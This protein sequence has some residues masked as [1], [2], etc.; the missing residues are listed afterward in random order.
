MEVTGVRQ[1]QAWQQA[2]LPPVEQVRPGLWSIPVP[3][4]DN[5]LRYVLVY[6][7]ELPDGVAIVDP[8]WDCDEAWH[9]LVT[10]LRTVGYDIAE[11][12]AVLVTHLH[13]DHFG[14][15]G[16]VR[17]A[18]GAWVAMHRADA[19]LL[20]HHEPAEAF[21][22]ARESQGQLRRA[23]APEYL[24]SGHHA[25]PLVRFDRCAGAEVLLGD[26]DRLD[27]PGWNLHAVG[28]PGHTPG[29]LCLFER[30][31]GVLLSGDHVLPRISPHISLIPG[32]LAD[33]LTS[34]LGSLR[35]IAA[36][37]VDEVLPAH[38]YRFRGLAER[39]GALLSH[40]AERLAE[41][42]RAVA[43][44]PGA[45]AWQLTTRLTWSRPIESM[46]ERLLR[47][48]LRETLAHLVVLQ[49]TCRLRASGDAVE[50]WFPISVVD[51]AGLVPASTFR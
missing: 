10:G 44:L 6:A 20:R 2:V 36:L 28:T 33:P 51:D 24:C 35:K 8:G 43:E 29:H 18:S 15:V 14:L 17:A 1:Q 45:T 7:F 41:I 32:Q 50:R 4:P 22:W 26:G 30:D 23:G 46:H 34:Y 21:G 39:V 25:V 3:I 5:P 49:G 38:E 40:H 19:A 48:A 37:D 47:F 42:E 27:L 31:L 16:R 13:P 9:S 11:V 12:R